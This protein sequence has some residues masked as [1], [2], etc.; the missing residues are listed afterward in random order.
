VS[1]AICYIVQIAI[2][3]YPLSRVANIFGSWL[4][5]IIKDLKLLVLSVAATVC[6]AIWRHR[7]DIVCKCKHVTNSLQVLH[8]AIYWLHF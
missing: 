4:E 6:W 2:N 3:I 8:L 5:G 1:R 7:N